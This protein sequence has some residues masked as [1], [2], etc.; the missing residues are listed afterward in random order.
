MPL[1]ATTLLTVPYHCGALSAA[2]SFV[3]GTICTV[4][5]TVKS[6]FIRGVLSFLQC[7]YM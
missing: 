5:P 2:A 1:V 3:M 6:G 7:V 4:I